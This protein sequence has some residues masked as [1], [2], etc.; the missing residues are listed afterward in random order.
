M[1][2]DNYFLNE[3]LNLEIVNLYLKTSET[4]EV[5]Q[6]RL[7]TIGLRIGEKLTEKFCLSPSLVITFFFFSLVYTS[8]ILQNIG[9]TLKRE[10]WTL[11]QRH[12]GMQ[13]LKAR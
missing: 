6:K 1:S 10:L 11:S 5:C 3:Y 13:R 2:T 12:S 7:E 9:R 4:Q 8:K